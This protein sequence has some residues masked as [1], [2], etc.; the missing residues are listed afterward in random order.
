MKIENSILNFEFLQAEYF[1]SNPVFNKKFEIQ[2]ILNV[3]NKFPSL[4]NWTDIINQSNIF[5]LL[6]SL[7]WCW[8]WLWVQEMTNFIQSGMT[9]DQSSMVVTV[10]VMYNL[11]TCLSTKIANLCISL[12]QGRDK[13]HK[14]F[15]YIWI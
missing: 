3:K 7:F 6:F 10:F 2:F 12:F 8:D 5:S 13:W 15:Y 11:Y 9:Y 1:S 4:S 14:A